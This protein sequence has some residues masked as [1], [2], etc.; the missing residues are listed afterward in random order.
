MQINLTAILE[1][2]PNKLADPVL[3]LV[4]PVENKSKKFS[5]HSSQSKEPKKSNGVRFRVQMREN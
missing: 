1:K 4:E 3:Q 2:K 5:K